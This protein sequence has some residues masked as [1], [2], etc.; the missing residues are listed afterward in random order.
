VAINQFIWVRH[1]CLIF[2]QTP[3]QPHLNN[4]QST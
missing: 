2:D 1:M 3:W 4:R